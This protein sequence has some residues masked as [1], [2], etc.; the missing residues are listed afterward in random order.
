M[1]IVRA[2]QPVMSAL[3][4]SMPTSTNKFSIKSFKLRFSLK[5]FAGKPARRTEYT[6]LSLSI[7]ANTNR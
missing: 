7:K 4:P 3:K 5:R 6:A 1:Y 2:N